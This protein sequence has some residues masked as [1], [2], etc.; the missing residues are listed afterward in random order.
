MQRV[1]L[2][3]H[4]IILL[5]G[6]LILNTSLAQRD[7]CRMDLSNVTQVAYPDTNSI[8]E[9]EWYKTTRMEVGMIDSMRFFM[10]TQDGCMRH[11]TQ[12]QL[13]YINQNPPDS[14]DVWIY[15]VENLVNTLFA[16]SASYQRVWKPFLEQFRQQFPAFGINTPFNISM[17]AIDF[18]CQ[19]VYYPN[20]EASLRIDRIAFLFKEKI[21]E[22]SQ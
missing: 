16:S 15:E 8:L 11:Y 6:L 5:G 22:S 9:Y 14:M 21:R 17:G 7:S 18:I 3:K 2:R 10:I 20:Q 1:I 13:F 19:V 12:I 4:V